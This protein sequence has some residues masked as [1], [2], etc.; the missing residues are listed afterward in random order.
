MAARVGA[1]LVLLLAAGPSL[2]AESW[3]KM[4]CMAGGGGRRP[5]M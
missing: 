5:R 4:L 2:A 3:D 1:A